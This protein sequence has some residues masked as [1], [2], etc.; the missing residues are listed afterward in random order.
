MTDFTTQTGAQAGEPEPQPEL[1]SGGPPE[2]STQVQPIPAPG[3]SPEAP[4]QVQPVLAPGDP[5]EPAPDDQPRQASRDL[6]EQPTEPVPAREDNSPVENSLPAAEEPENSVDLGRIGWS[7]TTLAFLIAMVV[8]AL[9]RD[10]GY[11]GV[12]LAVAVAAG[13]NLF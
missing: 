2:P 5:T 6:S 7:I 4:T 12:T 3:G 8:L 9:R 13:I 11:A 1:A 10:I